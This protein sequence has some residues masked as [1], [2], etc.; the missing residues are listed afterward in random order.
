LD[1]VLPLDNIAIGNI[2]KP[3]ETTQGQSVAKGKIFPSATLRANLRAG[4]LVAVYGR[5]DR[6]FKEPNR[7]SDDGRRQGHAAAES[8]GARRGADLMDGDRDRGSGVELFG[9]RAGRGTEDHFPCGNR[10]PLRCRAGERWSRLIVRLVAA[11]AVLTCVGCRGGS[12]T[13]PTPTPT[14]TPQPPP[15]ARLVI[16]VGDLDLLIGPALRASVGMGSNSAT[17]GRIVQ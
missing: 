7:S 6:M 4:T 11:I 1:G 14:P 5:L 10:E 2:S 17:T 8:S 15:S 16:V 3:R 13:A 12:A 9:V